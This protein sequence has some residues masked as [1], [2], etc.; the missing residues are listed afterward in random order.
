MQFYDESQEIV[1]SEPES[2]EQGPILTFLE[3]PGQEN[4]LTAGAVK[5]VDEDFL[6]KELLQIILI[7]LVGTIIFFVLGGMKLVR[8]FLPLAIRRIV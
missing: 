1:I 2:Q 4:N 7:V 3:E 8:P 6:P 5:T